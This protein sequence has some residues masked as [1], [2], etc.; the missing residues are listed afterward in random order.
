M[1]ICIVIILIAHS[2]CNYDVVEIKYS[3]TGEANTINKIGSGTV[4]VT[5]DG[6]IINNKCGNKLIKAGKETI[7]D[8]ANNQVIAHYSMIRNI[9]TD[10]TFISSRQMKVKLTSLLNSGNIFYLDIYLKVD[11]AEVD[12]KKLKEAYANYK[13]NSSSLAAIVLNPSQPKVDSTALKQSVDSL[14]K[15]MLK[16]E[17]ELNNLKS[18]G[19]KIT[20]QSLTISGKVT[21]ADNSLNQINSQLNQLNNKTQETQKLLNELVE[22]KIENTNEDHV[23]SKLMKDVEEKTKEFNNFETQL[24]TLAI[25]IEKL[26]SEMRFSNNTIQTKQ[27]E[28]ESLNQKIKVIEDKTCE[29]RKKHSSLTKENNS[30]SSSSILMEPAKKLETNKESINQNKEY[31]KVNL[32]MEV[33]KIFDEMNNIFKFVTGYMGNASKFF[34]NDSKEALNYIMAIKP[35]ISNG[36]YNLYDKLFNASGMNICSGVKKEMRKARKKNKLMK[37]TPA[38]VTTPSTNNQLIISTTNI[39][40]VGTNSVLQNT[41]PLS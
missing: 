12:K 14:E 33:S 30:S 13:K 8:T 5:K 34:N 10:I 3:E 26:E 4:C 17:A 24:K 11:L 41:I 19:V 35:N 25:E 31:E 29:A 32:K 39:N 6:I 21:E 20:T 18:E 7:Y 16:L 9:D 38:P 22:P 15:E 40:Q 27:A 1:A 36:N 28:I 23:L 2:K 37:S